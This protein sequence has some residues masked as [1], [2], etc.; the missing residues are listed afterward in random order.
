MKVARSSKRREECFHETTV[1]TRVT[2]YSP[3]RYRART[4]PSC[5]V[6]RHVPI[7]RYIIVLRSLLP[8]AT[9]RYQDRVNFFSHHRRERVTVYGELNRNSLDDPA[10]YRYYIRVHRCLLYFPL[11][12]ACIFP[13][14]PSVKLTTVI[15]SR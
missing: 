14:F 2:D 12:S 9:F 6:L 4:L 3:W 8:I 5:R 10:C 7:D 15:I 1:D 13:L 11:L